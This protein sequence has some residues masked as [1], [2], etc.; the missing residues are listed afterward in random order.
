MTTRPA[1]LFVAWTRTSGRGSDL[2]DALGGEAALIHP[3]IPLMRGPLSTVVRYAVSAVL[4]AGVLL[5]RG[6][7]AVIVT[8]P[9]LLP[10]LVVAAW[11]RAAG[12]PFV[13]DSHPSGFGLKG[14][15]LLARLQPVHAWLARRARAVL[16]TTQAFVERIEGWGGRGLVVHEPPVSFP[17]RFLPDTPVVLFV[18]IFAADEPVDIVLAAARQLPEVTFLVTGDPSR[19]PS[20]LL[21]D[22]PPNVTLTGY[23]RGD[24]YRRAVSSCSVLLTLTTEPESVM[25]SGYEAVYAHAPLV[26]TDTPVLR[27]T[28]PRAVFCANTSDAVAAAVSECLTAAR[29]TARWDEAARL[30][31]ERW[32]GQLACLREACRP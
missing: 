8:N 20:G 1:V 23:L 24:D 31:Q 28:F 25:R 3:R 19:A 6:P 18:G 32:D 14:K 11:A 2:A 26:V 21:A 16:V 29:D 13:L 12:R 30:Q 5:R 10:A 15:V 4:T 9:P 7:R 22:L 27:E 17:P